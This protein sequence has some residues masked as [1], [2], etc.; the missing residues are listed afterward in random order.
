MSPH[1]NGSKPCF[2]CGSYDTVLGIT[3]TGE[4]FQG[5]TYCNRWRFYRNY[6]MPEATLLK[7]ENQVRR[8]VVDEN[9]LYHADNECSKIITPK[10]I[11]L[12][13]F[14]TTAFYKFVKSVK[15]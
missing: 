3:E 10:N 11:L 6:I 12:M 13:N 8:I 7:L 2:S 15:G 14:D 9:R 4:F 1:P 5:C